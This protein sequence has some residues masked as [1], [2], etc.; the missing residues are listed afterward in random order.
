MQRRVS[1]RNKKKP[2]N[3]TSG[4]VQK[5]EASKHAM[6]A[7]ANKIEGEK[8]LNKHKHVAKDPVEKSSKRKR[9]TRKHK[10]DQL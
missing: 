8:S 6:S 9:T 7:T 5:R 4:D 2:L 10:L 3:D 1:D